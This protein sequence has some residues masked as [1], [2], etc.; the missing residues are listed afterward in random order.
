MKPIRHLADRGHPG[1]LRFRIRLR[2]IPH[3]DLNPGMRLKPLGHGGNLP[4]REQ[5]EGS[6]SCEITHERAIGVTIP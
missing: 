3:K 5:G 6:P 2:A 1:A 4:I